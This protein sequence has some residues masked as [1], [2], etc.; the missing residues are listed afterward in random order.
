MISDTHKD[1]KQYWCYQ[2][3]NIS[4]E[5]TEKLDEHLKLCMNHEAVSAILPEKDKIDKYGNREDIL[6]FKNYGNFLTL[7]QYI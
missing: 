1:N 5:P 7:F 6:K 2:R 3:L 4:Y